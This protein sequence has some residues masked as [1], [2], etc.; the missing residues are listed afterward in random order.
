MSVSGIF[1]SIADKAQNA[2]NQTP[3][4]GHI[5]S[6]GHS[7]NQAN[8]ANPAAS[9]SGGRSLALESLQ[10]QIRSLGQQ[11]SSATP[12]QRIITLEKGVALGFDGV[13]RDNKAQSKELYTWGQREDPDLTDVTDRL[14]Y[15]NFTQ[16]ALS[17]SLSAQLDSARAS[18]KPL[19]EA[20]AAILPKRN[21]RA[22]LRNQITRIEH[23]PEKGAER[24]RRLA[25]LKEQLSRAESHD[26]QAEK[27]LELLKRKVI[28]ESE[29]NKWEAIRE[30]GEKLVLLAEAA[31]PIIG[32]LPT[33]PP[34]TTNPYAGAPVTAGA[35]ASLQHALDN[36][37]P[38]QTNL[39]LQIGADLS[40][41]GSDT[42]SFGESHASGMAAGQDS[43]PGLSV[44]P[45]IPEP[46]A[47]ASP[48]QS[49]SPIPAQPV[50][51][52]VQDTN[53]R[54]SE[55]P[56]EASSQDLYS[57]SP[58][59]TES[60]GEE[61]QRLEREERERVQAASNERSSVPGSAEEEKSRLERE[62]RER[63]LAGGANPVGQ[64][65]EELPPYREM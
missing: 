29:Q 55:S 56:A 43:H 39:D 64:D 65:G 33:L 27:E 4:A 37:K 5:P 61:K 57:T 9:H 51:G 31:K 35:R 49:A 60:A 20:E 22:G 45:P 52:V 17:A 34:T 1:S 62:E 16:G 40:R 7:A 41:S 30:Y 19:R 53:A 47:S 50:S 14:A 10:H 46:P 28:R 54:A 8:H 63:V 2:I 21:I 38:G 59:K 42:R 18:L 12:M 58:V 36:Y 23:S 25:E 3:L 32:A 26:E 11:Y 13:A 48:N 44:T 15:L 6:G 24:E